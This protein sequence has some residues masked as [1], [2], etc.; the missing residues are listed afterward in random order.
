MR[1]NPLRGDWILVSPHRM[2]RP[3]AGQVEKPVG[4]DIPAHDPKNPLC[5]GVVRPN[6]EVRSYVIVIIIIIIILDVG[7]LL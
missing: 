2:K 3:W 6:G 7:R 4:E 5:P 1:F